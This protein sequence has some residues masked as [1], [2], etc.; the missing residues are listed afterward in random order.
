MESRTCVEVFMLLFML[1]VCLPTLSRAQAFEFD[2]IGRL[3]SDATVG[4][5]VLPYNIS[6]ILRNHEAIVDA[7][8]SFKAQARKVYGASAQQQSAACNI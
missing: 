8:A 4:H 6:G 2:R 5:L 7:F 1:C 3:A